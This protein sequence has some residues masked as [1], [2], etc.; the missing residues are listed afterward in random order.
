MDR[1]EISEIIL[2]LDFCKHFIKEICEN[3]KKKK[4]S[5]WRFHALNQK[6]TVSV[7]ME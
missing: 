4:E 6:L 5:S 1:L 2:F 3:T 7:T